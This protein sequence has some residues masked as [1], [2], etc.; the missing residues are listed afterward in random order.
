DLAFAS[1]TTL[2]A[3]FRASSYCRRVSG[4][5]LAIH[6]LNNRFFSV[7]ARLTSG[8]HHDVQRWPPGNTPMRFVPQHLV[9]A[10]SSAVLKRLHSVS[11]SAEAPGR[12]WN[13]VSIVVVIRCRTSG[14]WSSSHLTL[15]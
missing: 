2:P 15:V 12:S 9:A 3:S 14:F 8:D 7:T 10:L 13:L 1:A 5:F 6:D 11:M 4:V